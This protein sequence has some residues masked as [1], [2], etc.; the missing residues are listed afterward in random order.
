MR[1]LFKIYPQNFTGNFTKPW[2]NRKSQGEWHQQDGGTGVFYPLSPKEHWFWQSHTD[3]STF[4]GPRSCRE[5]QHTIG[6]TKKFETGNTEE[7]KQNSFTFPMSPRRQGGTA[8]C[9]KMNSACSLSH[10]GKWEHVSEFPS[11]PAVK[12]T[13]KNTHFFLTRSEYRGDLHD[14]GAGR[15]WEHNSQCSEL[16]KE[17]RSY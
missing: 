3:A 5:V 14:G 7:S 15:D 6:R 2:K 4:V 10:R 8:Q 1:M 16:N 12:H 17:H 13:V 9:R 11:S